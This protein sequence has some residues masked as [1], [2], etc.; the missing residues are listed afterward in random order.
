MNLIDQKKTFSVIFALALI[1]LLAII[2][3]STVTRFFADDFCE[4]S[5]ANSMNIL[6]YVKSRY[7]GWTGRFS[8][9]LFS[10]LATSLGP[11]FASIFPSLIIISWF[12]SLT[13]STYQVLCILKYPNALISALSYSSFFLLLLFTSLP[14][15]YESVF[16]LIGSINYSLPL[17]GFNILLGLSIY[18]VRKNSNRFVGF[19]FVILTF[20]N[21]GFSEI[22]LLMQTT[23]IFITLAFLVISRNYKTQ[24]NLTTYIILGLIISLV[25]FFIVWIAPGNAV[26]Q[27]ASSHPQ[28][29]PLIQLP[30]LIFRSTMVI[31]YSFLVNFKFWFILVL[32]IS[33]L[34]GFLNNSKMSFSYRKVKSIKE[35]FNQQWFKLIITI[36]LFVFIISLA[37]AAPSS[38]IQGEYPTRR[39]VILPFYFVLNGIIAIMSIFGALVRESIVPKLTTEKNTLYSWG[40]ILLIMLVFLRVSTIIIDIYHDWPNHQHY[41]E[42]WDKRDSEFQLMISKGVRDIQAENVI[43]GFGYGD[44]TN[45]PKNWVNRCMAD[46]YGF[47]SISIKE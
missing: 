7:V 9:I 19:L 43:S 44:L 13:F 29:T 47:N 46:Y 1:G 25:A 40:S 24:K 10:G 28:P 4:A 41:A 31:F 2:I 12:I 22:Y 45:N 16:W 27:A 33:F 26:R 30:F 8:F 32:I 3:M 14:K 21:S 18:L 42:S 23:I 6:D 35:L 20:I 15:L 11:K 38:Y 37:S 17:I 36:S 34:L 39:A 5:L